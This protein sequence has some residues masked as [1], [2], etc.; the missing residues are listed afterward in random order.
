[1]VALALIFSSL[2]TL[3]TYEIIRNI[4]SKKVYEVSLNNIVIKDKEMVLKVNSLEYPLSN[5]IEKLRELAKKFEISYFSI[6]HSTELITK[7]SL[8]NPEVVIFNGKGEK[9]LAMNLSVILITNNL[10]IINYGNTI[11]PSKK[12][13]ILIRAPI[14]DE[15]T[16]KL[17]SLIGITNIVVSLNSDVIPPTTAPIIIVLG[18]DYNTTYIWH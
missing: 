8:V 18:K 9:N 16:K 6:Y 2:I 12:S 14:N 15:Y 5:D 17:S 11:K 4:E 3:V 1:V 10:N 13:F 7:A